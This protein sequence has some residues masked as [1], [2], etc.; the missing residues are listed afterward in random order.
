MAESDDR[1][2]SRNKS[3]RQFEQLARHHRS[4]RQKEQGVCLPSDL[5]S[6]I[7]DYGHFRVENLIEEIIEIELVPKQ[8]L[9]RG[10]QEIGQ[11]VSVGPQIE[12]GPQAFHGKRKQHIRDVIAARIDETQP[13]DVLGK[14]VVEPPPRLRRRVRGRKIALSQPPQRHERSVRVHELD[15]AGLGPVEHRLELLRR[16]RPAVSSPYLAK[17]ARG[18]AVVGGAAE[19]LRIEV[20]M[21]HHPVSFF[22]SVFVAEDVGPRHV[23]T[24]QWR[25]KADVRH[26]QAA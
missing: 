12:F 1:S 3:L 8:R 16:G 10:L 9:G 26:G 22:E 15:T 7:L 14:L 17:C 24:A 20:R 13:G 4:K 25:V 11:P 18:A 23:H 6:A 5:D 21:L 19:G 2:P